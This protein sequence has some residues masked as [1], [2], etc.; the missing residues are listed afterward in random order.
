MS[1]LPGMDGYD[2]MSGAGGFCFGDLCFALAYGCE[3]SPAFL[4]ECT[5][6]LCISETEL[7]GISGFFYLARFAFYSRKARVLYYYIGGAF[8]NG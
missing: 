4:V 3:A 5:V 1:V 7:A 2:D 6:L 8:G